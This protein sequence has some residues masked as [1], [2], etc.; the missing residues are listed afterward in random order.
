M[1]TWEPNL[2]RSI[3]ASFPSESLHMSCD[4]MGIILNPSMWTVPPLVPGQSFSYV[5]GASSVSL[6]G[7]TVGQSL[8]AAA[9]R[10]PHREALVFVQDGVR[11]TFSQF[12]EDVGLSSTL[13]SNLFHHILT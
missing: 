6:L 11:K 9:D 12:Q 3:K 2:V 1:D 7:Q 4:L 13:S 10:W 5:H 8:Q